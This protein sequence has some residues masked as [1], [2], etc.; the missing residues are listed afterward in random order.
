VK[1]AIK[2][3]ARHM[4]RQA[5]AAGGPKPVRASFDRAGSGG[6]RRGSMYKCALRH[7]RV[8]ERATRWAMF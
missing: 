4:G 1:L 3:A 8:I 2:L 5:K 6:T 7:D